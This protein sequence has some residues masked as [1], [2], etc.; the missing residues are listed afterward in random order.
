M[1]VHKSPL[2]QFSEFLSSSGN[3][4]EVICHPQCSHERRR[5]H[6]Q[7]PNSNHRQTDRQTDGR[8]DGSLMTGMTLLSPVIFSLKLTLLVSKKPQ[9]AVRRVYF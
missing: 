7:Q 3:R 1:P 4:R 8:T 5:Q 6:R 9:L 2:I